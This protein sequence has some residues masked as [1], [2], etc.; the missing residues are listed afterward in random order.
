MPPARPPVRLRLQGWEDG[1]PMDR[2]VEVFD[3]WEAHGATSITI[4]MPDGVEVVLRQRPNE[5]GAKKIGVGACVWEGEVLLA[6]FLAEEL[7]GAP[8]GAEPFRGKTVLELGAG[9]GAAG[10]YLAKLGRGWR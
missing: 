5:Q 10:L 6:A 3:R 2:V 9:P 7:A 8:R 1:E 4:M